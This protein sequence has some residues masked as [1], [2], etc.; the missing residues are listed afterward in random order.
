MKI[1]FGGCYNGVT[2]VKCKLLMRYGAVVS[3]WAPSFVTLS[4]CRSVI[5]TAEKPK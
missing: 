1:F 5:L 4:G 2:G 3:D